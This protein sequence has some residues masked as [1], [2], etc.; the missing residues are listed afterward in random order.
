MPVRAPTTRTAAVTSTREHAMTKFHV[1]LNV[2]E[3]ARALAFYR[4]L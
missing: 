3:L 4:T 1:S 2:S